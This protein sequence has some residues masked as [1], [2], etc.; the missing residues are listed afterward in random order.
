MKLRSC[1]WHVYAVDGYE[2]SHRTEA[3]AVRAAHT[4]ARRRGVAYRVLATDAYG[5][6]GGGRGTLVWT[7]DV[8]HPRLS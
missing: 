5:L 1:R 4:G 8:D 2:S 6:T 3:A 7:S